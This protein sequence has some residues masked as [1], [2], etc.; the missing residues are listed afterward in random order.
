MAT[1]VE[2]RLR[3]EKVRRYGSGRAYELPPDLT[4]IQ[5]AS[6]ADFL[7]IETDPLKRKPHGIEGVLKEIFPIES[8]SLIHI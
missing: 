8:L 5:T 4:K 1:P 2:R 3:P 7:Q 6:F